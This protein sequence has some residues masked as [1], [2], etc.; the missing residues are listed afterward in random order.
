M[1]MKALHVLRVGL[2]NVLNNVSEQPLS[3]NSI[4]KLVILALHEKSQLDH[5]FIRSKL[6]VRKK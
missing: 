6:Y 2:F 5:A 3:Y 4:V 1:T